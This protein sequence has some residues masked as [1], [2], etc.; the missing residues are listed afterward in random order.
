MQ[1][2][3]IIEVLTRALSVDASTFE[4]QTAGDGMP[5]VYVAPAALVDTCRALRDL[6]ELR[7]VVLVDIV[8]VDYYPRTPRFELVYILACPGV[9]GFG[10]RP[11]RLRL[12][13]RVLGEAGADRV[14]RLAVG[15]LG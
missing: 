7:F 10:D 2:P 5:T 13:V 6:A 4:A 3:A 8:A 15:Q 11:R 9:A 1:A 12:K 14:G